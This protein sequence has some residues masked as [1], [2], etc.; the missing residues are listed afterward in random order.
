MFRDEIAVGGLGEGATAM[1]KG[2]DPH[3]KR[4][5]FTATN[6]WN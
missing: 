5:F 1:E 6:S 2:W 3:V 4:A